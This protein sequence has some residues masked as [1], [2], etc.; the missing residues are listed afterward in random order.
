MSKSAVT[1]MTASI[2]FAAISCGGQQ[3]SPKSSAELLEQRCSACHP[4]SRATDKKKTAEEWDVTV[5][6]MMDKGAKLSEE[7]KQT[8]VN[9]LAATYKP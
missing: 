8:L 3:S 7:E 1:V 4:A 5:Q 2:V 6:R 9:Y